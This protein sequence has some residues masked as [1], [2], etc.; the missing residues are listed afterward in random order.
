MTSLSLGRKGYA[1]DAGNEGTGYPSNLK[2]AGHI[3]DGK[4]GTRGS[5]WIKTFFIAKDDDNLTF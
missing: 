3:R 1:Y 5:L 2:T 4:I